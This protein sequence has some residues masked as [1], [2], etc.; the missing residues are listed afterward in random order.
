VKGRE[1]E[2]KYDRSRAVTVIDLDD[3]ELTSFLRAVA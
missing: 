3:P 2:F 1:A